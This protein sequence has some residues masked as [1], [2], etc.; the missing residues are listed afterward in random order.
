MSNITK[1]LDSMGIS[2]P[3]LPAPAAN[4]L[5]YVAHN[6]LLFVSG[7]LPFEDGEIAV[8]GK[9]GDTVSLE[10]GIRAAKLCAINILAATG[11][12]FDGD[13]ERIVRLVRIGGFV[14]STPSFTKQPL[15]IN[16]ASDFLCEVL[17]E[18]GKHSRVAVGVPV[19]PRDV[20][21]EIDALFAYS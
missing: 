21:V 13:F 8:V 1:R 5:P 12:A 11:H 15:V 17:G 3:D 19:L 4:Y 18:R 9:L 16:G 10:E 6:G 2:L 20:A 14:S 7:Q